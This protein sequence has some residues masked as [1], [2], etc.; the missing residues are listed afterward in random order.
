[1][2]QVLPAPGMPLDEVQTPSLILDLPVLERNIAMVNGFFRD[3]PAKV[4]SVTKGHKCP[5]IAQLQMTAEGAVP[6]GLACAKVSE[7]E[8]MVAAGAR[9][10]RMIEQVVGPDKLARLM[11]LA[12]RAEVIALVDDP[13]Q[14]DTL[15]E[16]AGA[17]GV[18]PGVM[19]EIDIGLR[20]CGVQPGTPAVTLAQYITRH[21]QLRFQGLS[22]HESSNSIP[23]PAE[24]EARQRMHFQRLVDTRADLERA[25]LPVA[26]CAGGAT[27]AWRVAGTMDG[28]TEVEPGAYATADYGLIRAVPEMGY[29]LALK[30]VAT[31]LSRPVPERAVLDC[32]HKMVGVNLGGGM[33]GVLA[34]KGATM[35]RLNSEHGILDLQQDA[36]ALRIGDKI[37]LYPWYYGAVINANRHYIGIRDGRVECVWEI[38]AQGAHQ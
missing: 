2:S 5:A 31:V 4:R 10:I 23:D 32:G 8:I 20:R 30:V 18:T 14:V 19:V 6:Y 34:P 33:P 15:A 36:R 9:S 3:R 13:V 26:I 24:R 37:E 28:V 35:E 21:R 11:C 22:G 7:A 12:R 29:G 25:G 38:A 16:A 1:M 17:F 27:A